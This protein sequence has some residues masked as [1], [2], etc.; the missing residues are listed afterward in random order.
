MIVHLI[1]CD[2]VHVMDKVF[3]NQIWWF[4]TESL[5]HFMEGFR[6]LLTLPRIGGTIDVV[7]IQL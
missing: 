7:H 5:L 4:K 6:E 3:K 1:L 2:F